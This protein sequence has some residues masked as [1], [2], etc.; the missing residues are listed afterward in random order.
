MTTLQIVYL[1]SKENSHIINQASVHAKNKQHQYTLQHINYR[2]HFKCCH[3][4]LINHLCILQHSAKVTV[5]NIK[6]SGSIFP[7]IF[8]HSYSPP[9]EVFELENGT[10]P[11]LYTPNCE[12]PRT[13]VWWNQSTVHLYVG[14]TA[15]QAHHI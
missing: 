4:W 5:H 6:A 11:Y 1:S 10:A 9:F 2:T 3:V 14:G 8:S 7:L 15:I 13:S 12:T